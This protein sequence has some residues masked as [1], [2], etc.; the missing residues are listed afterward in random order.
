MFV[1]PAPGRS[2]R[3]PGTL[4][5]LEAE[6]A[7]VPETDFWLRCLARGDVEKTTPPAQPAPIP[8]TKP[9]GASA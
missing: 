6:G 9:D 8:T 7:N 5:L 3:W 4:R 1:K 2:V